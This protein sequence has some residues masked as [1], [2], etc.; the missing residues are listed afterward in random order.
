MIVEG[1]HPIERIFMALIPCDKGM[2]Q[3]KIKKKLEETFE[4][5]LP[6]NLL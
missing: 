6:L 4:I 2:S 5:K 1:K 3:N